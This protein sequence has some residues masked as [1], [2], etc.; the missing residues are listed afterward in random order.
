MS[1]ES[2]SPSLLTSRQ[3][4]RGPGGR[5]RGVRVAA[6]IG[7]EARRTRLEYAVVALARVDPETV[8]YDQ[9]DRASRYAGDV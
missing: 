4:D 8:E 2:P 9:D 7:I 3:A 5:E 6:E 1:P